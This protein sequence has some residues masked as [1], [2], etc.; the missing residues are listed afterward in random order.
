MKIKI[1]KGKDVYIPDAKYLTFQYYRFSFLDDPKGRKEFAEDRVKRFQSIISERLAQSFNITD[2]SAFFQLTCYFYDSTTIGTFSGESEVPFLPNLSCFMNHAPLEIR[3]KFV[4]ALI[5]KEYLTSDSG[6]LFENKYIIGC[7]NR[8]CD[9]MSIPWKGDINSLV[10]LFYLLYFLKAIEV[11]DKFDT[12]KHTNRPKRNKATSKKYKESTLPTFTTL[13]GGK[14]I[15][16]KE[17]KIPRGNF[18]IDGI[19][20]QEKWHTINRRCGGIRKNLLPFFKDLI[21]GDQLT[22]IPK[23]MLLERFIERKDN[24]ISLESSKKDDKI[25]IDIINLIYAYYCSKETKEANPEPDT[26]KRPS[27]LRRK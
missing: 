3:T 18:I 4:K 21:K 25:D 26:G 27:L 9:A 24:I 22:I 8:I 14:Y 17:I 11:D 20:S 23:K 12:M 6:M 7:E 1:F 19:N 15:K 10:T 16:P 13:I 2:L 5:Q